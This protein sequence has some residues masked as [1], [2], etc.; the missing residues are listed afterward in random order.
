MMGARG[1][2]ADDPHLQ[3]PCQWE[4]KARLWELRGDAFGTHSVQG[5]GVTIL[6]MHTGWCGP[7]LVTLEAEEVGGEGEESAGMSMGFTRL[8]RDQK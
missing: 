4:D 8:R 7:A 6:E 2:E 1:V 3:L 5:S